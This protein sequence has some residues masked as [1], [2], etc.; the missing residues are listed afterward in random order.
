MARS[1]AQKKVKF[2]GTCR[3]E[4]MALTDTSDAF[5]HLARRATF[6]LAIMVPFIDRLGAEWA[7]EVF[8]E[9]E[10][11]E[12][13]RILR[14]AGQLNY[15]GRKVRDIAT[16]IKQYGARRPRPTNLIETFYAKIVLADGRSHLCRLGSCVAPEKFNSNAEYWLRGPPYNRSS[17]HAV[18]TTYPTFANGAMSMDTQSF[19]PKRPIVVRET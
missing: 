1:T 2:M 12:R 18:P 11:P 7:H 14:D 16:A 17:H 13:I 9:T 3:A 6:R 5:R 10:A 4:T 8:A 19:T 15:C